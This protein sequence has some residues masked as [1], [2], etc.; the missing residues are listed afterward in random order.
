[1]KALNNSSQDGTD[2]GANGVNLPLVSIV[3]PSYNQ[4]RFIGQTIQSVLS[5]NYP[6]MEY[7][8]VDGDSTDNTKQILGHYA[9]KISICVSEPDT[10]QSDAINKGFRLA[11]GEIVA[12][13]N[14]DDYYYPDALQHA[15][16]IFQTDEALDVLYG[17]CVYVDEEGQFLRY[18]TEVSEFDQEKL[19]N[20]SNF[21]M[22]PATFFRRRAL[23]RVDFLR[24]ELNFT[25]D[26]DLWCRL[27]R[28]GCKFKY[29]RRLFAVNREY[30]LA[31][32]S[33]GKLSRWYEILQTNRAHKTTLIPWTALSFGVSNLLR[34]LTIGSL[35]KKAMA[36]VRS[37]KRTLFREKPQETLHGIEP[38]GRG[39]S[40]RFRITFPWYVCLPEA[41]EIVFRLRWE[42]KADMKLSLN[43]GEGVKEAF[44]ESGTKRVVLQIKED[45]FGHII[46]V[47]GEWK[48]GTSDRASLLLESIR[49]VSK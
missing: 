2:R 33:T 21:I 39:L 47:N 22:Q 20:V 27:A 5:Q 28:E 38:H 40:E 35:N 36:L 9:D 37:L 24:E 30:A 42:R 29:E 32:T 48:A 17:D 26:W 7:I 25:M 10:G 44:S 46:D 49:V 11:R 14:S 45:S 43:N 1:M 15:V 13:I 16:E 6:N 4:G 23:D 34:A 41:V 19:L 18:F 12:W 3:T 8:I 31:K